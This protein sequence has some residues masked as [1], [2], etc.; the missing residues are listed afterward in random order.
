MPDLH[1]L[2]YSECE[3]LLR[4]GVAGRVAFVDDSDRPMIVPVN[5]AVVATRS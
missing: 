4:A 5:Y 2:R 1:E 3:A